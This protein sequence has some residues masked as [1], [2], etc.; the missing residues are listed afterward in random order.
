LLLKLRSLAQQDRYTP[1][2]QQP[3]QPLP[4]QP[5]PQQQQPQQQSATEETAPPP[6]AKYHRKETPAPAGCQEQQSGPPANVPPSLAA[7][8][9]PAVSLADEAN[10]SGDS[11]GGDGSVSLAPTALVSGGADEAASAGSPASSLAS[12]GQA[13]V[14]C[15]DAGDRSPAAEAP[16][17]AS[18]VSTMSAPKASH[19][20]CDFI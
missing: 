13:A 4:P 10:A 15:L 1:L 20:L 3:E 11:N 12:P 18:Q 14:P 8:P 17:V 16:P 19:R 7:A 5:S 6:P 9:G 2:K